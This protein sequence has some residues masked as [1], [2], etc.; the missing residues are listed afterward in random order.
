[1]TNKKTLIAI[2]AL[3]ALVTGATSLMPEAEAAIAHTPLT[4]S[5]IGFD[6]VVNYSFDIESGEMTYKYNTYAIGCTDRLEVTNIYYPESNK[7]SLAWIFPSTINA[8]C[9][10]SE[11]SDYTLFRLTGVEWSIQSDGNQTWKHRSPS[12]QGIA[13][14]DGFSSDDG[15]VYG[16]FTAHYEWGS[17]Y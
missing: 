1:M 4:T 3:A 2:V 14:H 17:R 7:Q 16:T 11:L 6:T 13:Y 12:N 10:I 15:M 9:E 5:L 8:M